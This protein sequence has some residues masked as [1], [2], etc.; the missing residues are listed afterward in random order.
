M[1]LFLVL[2]LA[3]PIVAVV[4]FLA[5][6][7]GMK[8]GET[9]DAPTRRLILAGWVMVALLVVG[10][11]WL[12][13]V[14]RNRLDDISSVLLLV[15]FLAFGLGFLAHQWSSRARGVLVVAGAV[16]LIGHTLSERY[17]DGGASGVGRYVLIAAAVVVGIDLALVLL[18]GVLAARERRPTNRLSSGNPQP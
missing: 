4:L 8:R 2:S 16:G 17:I 14:S 5:S 6:F 9:S 10:V 13:W 7:A 11:L 15:A 18:N 12:F 1:D 3:V